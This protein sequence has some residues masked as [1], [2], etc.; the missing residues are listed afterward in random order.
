[1]EKRTLIVVKPRP[2]PHCKAPAGYGDT[3]YRC[4]SCGQG[5]CSLCYKTDPDGPGD[6][7]FCPSCKA[8]L[9]FPITL[10]TA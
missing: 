10:L 5:F 7:V 2:C 4:P 3:D 8:T 6:Y 1:M 9:Y